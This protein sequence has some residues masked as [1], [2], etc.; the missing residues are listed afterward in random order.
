MSELGIYFTR[1]LRVGLSNSDLSPSRGMSLETFAQS[2]NSALGCYFGTGLEGPNYV[3]KKASGP[4][5]ND[6]K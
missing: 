1:N 4:F 5:D 2:G 6:A 3:I